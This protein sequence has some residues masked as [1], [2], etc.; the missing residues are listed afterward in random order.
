MGF[1]SND[2]RCR[3]NGRKAG[4][5][6]IL[7][8]ILVFLAAQSAA[9]QPM[10]AAGIWSDQSVQD[11][12]MNNWPTLAEIEGTAWLV[13]DCQT[14]ETLLADN[15][16]LTVWPASTTKIMTAILT[17]EADI[18]DKTVTVSPTAV[19]LPYGSSK[20]GY[21]AGEVVVVRDVLAGLMLGSGN[22]A[23]NVLAE[24]LG[25]SQEGFAAAMNQKAMELGLSGSHFSN[26]S[27]LHDELHYV[28]ARDMAVLAAYAMKNEQFRDLV[29]TAT[30]SMP[31]TNMHPFSGWGM[32]NN[33]NRFI[34]FGKTA[35]SSALLD[36]YQGIKTGSTDV[37]GNNLVSAA[38]TRNGHELVA[39]I[40]G[41]PLNSKKGNPYIYSRTLFEAAAAKLGTPAA[42]AAPT[43]TATT[44][45]ATAAA[46]TMPSTTT[47]TQQTSSVGQQETKAGPDPLGRFLME[48]PWRTSF[49]VLLIFFL[50]LIALIILYFRYTRRRRKIRARR[51]APR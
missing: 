35:L 7:I 44:S 25:G 40:F 29:T 8:L 47:L 5:A 36:H 32:F 41:V 39:V 33:T 49:L 37:A 10:A 43:P 11:A 34:Q 26:P 17:L 12:G 1:E 2:R 45:A 23:A 48:N 22:D 19:N 24:T 38:V 21:M 42:T 4:L 30:Y 50:L 18:L 20:V 9:A 27:G 46:T 6:A 31:A 51:S 15:A 16:D 28:T 13:L 14:G 3:M